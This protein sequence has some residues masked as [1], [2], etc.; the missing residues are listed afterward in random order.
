LIVTA[1]VEVHKIKRATAWLVFGILAGLLCLMG[2]GSQ[3]AARRMSGEM[4]P[5]VERMGEMGDDME[6]MTPEDAG[7][8]LGDFLKGLQESTEEK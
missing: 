6:D 8:A 7:K 5:W 3:C 4:A 1:S 2:V